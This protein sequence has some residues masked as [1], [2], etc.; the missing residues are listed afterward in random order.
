MPGPDDQLLDQLNQTLEAADINLA[1]E[2]QGKTLFLSGEVDSERNRQAALDIARA[3]ANPTGWA[4]DDAIEIIDD[5]NIAGPSATIAEEMGDFGYVDPDTVAYQELEGDVAGTQPDTGELDPDFTDDVGTTDSELAAAEAIPYFPPTDP[6]VHV[7]ADDPEVL[8][9][10]GG[11]SATSMDDLSVDNGT[12]LPRDD[13]IT[14]AVMRELRE[15]ALTIDLA[16]QADTRNGIVVLRG[17]VETMEDAENAEAV[18]RRVE[19][20][21]DVVEQLTVLVNQHRGE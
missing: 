11:F 21:Q 7:D 13:D 15:D 4:I 3:V 20:V 5:D 18:A 10:V 16:I 6:V 2:L 1:V 12:A 14:D 9:V 8:E 19:G 17:T